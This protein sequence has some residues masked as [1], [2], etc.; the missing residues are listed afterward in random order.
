MRPLSQNIKTAR[1]VIMYPLQVQLDYTELKFSLRS[2]EKYIQEPFEVVIIGEILPGWITNITHLKLKDIPGRKQLS[3][4]RK[5]LAGLEYSD[6]VFFMNDDIYLLNPANTANYPFYYSGDL[7]TIGETGGR[8]LM[9]QLKAQN[10]PILHYDIH[11]PIIYERAKFKEL[12]VFGADCIIKSM[13]CNYHE[14]EGRYCVDMKYNKKQDSESIK[15]EIRHWMWVNDQPCF[16]TGPQGL[17]SVLP[18]LENLFPNKSKY[19]L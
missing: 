5:I 11:T 13:Y 2:L 10:K 7:S 14:I 6:E 8:L 17:L 3:I 12:E 9:D 19:E 4:R 1:K 18:V 15:Q 16:S